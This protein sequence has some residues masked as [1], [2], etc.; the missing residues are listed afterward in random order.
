MNNLPGYTAENS[1]YQKRAHYRTVN[2]PEAMKVENAV[3]SQIRAPLFMGSRP[4]GPTGTIGLP[5]QNCYEAC[6]HV[7][8]TV[9]W[10]GPLEKCIEKCT[11]TCH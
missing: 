11:S 8:M 5:G 7:C 1:L 6:W 2:N 4:T 3:Y 10:W 9:G